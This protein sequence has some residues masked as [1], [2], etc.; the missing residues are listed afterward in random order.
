MDELRRRGSALGW[1]LFQNISYI[2]KYQ[3]CLPILSRLHY[4]EVKHFGLTLDLRDFIFLTSKVSNWYILD[5]RRVP[6]IRHRLSVFWILKI[7]P[8]LLRV[9]NNE[10]VTTKWV[11]NFDGATV[12]PFLATDFSG[13]LSPRLSWW[14][15][16]FDVFGSTLY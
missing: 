8:T 13:S 12:D 16:N 11:T 5:L 7:E 1:T 3:T 2:H 10:R 6:F 15:T 14:L 9:W 4:F